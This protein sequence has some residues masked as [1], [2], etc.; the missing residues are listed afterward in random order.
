VSRA[1][2]GAEPTLLLCGI[3]IVLPTLAVL[4]VRDVREPSAVQTAASVDP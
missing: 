2:A 4:M 1:R 3:G